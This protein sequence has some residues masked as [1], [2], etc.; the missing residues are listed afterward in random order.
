MSSHAIF[1]ALDEFTAALRGHA[2][3]MVEAPSRQGSDP[4]IEQLIEAARKYALTIEAVGGWWVPSLFDHDQYDEDDEDE[5][6]EAPPASAPRFLG[7]RWIGDRVLK[8]RGCRG[9]RRARR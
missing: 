2:E 8:A 4:R 9:R 6:I 5:H 1:L 3:A 7:G